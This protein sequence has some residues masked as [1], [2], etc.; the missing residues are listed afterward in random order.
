M[1]FMLKEVSLTHFN[2]VTHSSLIIHY[3]N[4]ISIRR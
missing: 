1:I 3:V 4:N 2:M